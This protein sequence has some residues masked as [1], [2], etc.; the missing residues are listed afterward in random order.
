MPPVN[1]TETDWWFV[2]RGERDDPDQDG[3]AD[4]DDNSRLTPMLLTIVAKRTPY[5][6]TSMQTAITPMATRI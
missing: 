1:N 3:R 6:F 5:R 4:G 2:G